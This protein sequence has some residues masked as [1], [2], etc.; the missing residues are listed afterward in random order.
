MST[1]TTIYFYGHTR[2]YGYLSNFYSAP[3]KLY[4][5]GHEY[6]LSTSEHAFQAGK[7]TTRSDV[8]QVA[9]AP[10]PAA[11]KAAGRRITMSADWESAYDAKKWSETEHKTSAILFNKLLFDNPNSNNT[12][13]SQT[14]QWQN[15]D[16]WMFTVVLHKFT[17]NRHLGAQ[18]VQTGA[19]H[20][21]EHT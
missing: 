18:L 17:Q 3:L 13:P 7:A 9:S 16:F 5:L 14:T 6:Q 15:R 12:A 10:S 21:V 1:A 19:A 4:I 8:E 11:A 2:P 20:L